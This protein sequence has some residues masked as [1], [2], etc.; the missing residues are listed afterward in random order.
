MTDLNQRMKINNDFCL[1]AVTITAIVSIAAMAT[2]VLKNGKTNVFLADDKIDTPSSE[3][4]IVCKIDADGKSSNESVLKKDS[5]GNI[6]VVH[7]GYYTF[8]AGIVRDNIG[9]VNPI[10]LTYE[11]GINM[12][13]L[14]WGPGDVGSNRNPVL[15]F[16]NEKFKFIDRVMKIQ[17]MSHEKFVTISHQPSMQGGFSNRP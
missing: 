3:D 6:E 2:A 12:C 14:T 4:V 11:D 7:T 15:L 13:E 8:F 5:N 10:M 16:K 9:N 1:A 17:Y